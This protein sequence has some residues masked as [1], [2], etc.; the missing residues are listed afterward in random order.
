MNNN[1]NNY[2]N[3]HEDEEEIVDC[4]GSRDVIFRKGPTYKNNPGNMYFREL[5]ESAH[6]E[7]TK[8]SRK[9]KSNITWKIVREIEAINGRF[10]DWC[11]TR[12]MWIVAKDREKIRRKVSA[13]Y[14]QYNTR[15]QKIQLQQQKQQQQQ[16]PK[17][18]SSTIPKQQIKRTESTSGE[19]DEDLD[20]SLPQMFRNDS[21]SPKAGTYN[22]D[23]LVRRL[24]D[25][26]EV[27]PLY[28]ST[29]RR[30]TLEY[31]SSDGSSGCGGC[32]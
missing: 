16:R 15:L 23:K 13:C 7:H 30:K 11:T 28:T 17:K 22:N 9:G 6:G 2:N 32:L 4:P 5:I 29:K 14:K 3:I 25:Y 20:T 24:R 18:Q 26:Y 21:H 27:T 10:L 8:A 12:E 1:G 31:D 19:S